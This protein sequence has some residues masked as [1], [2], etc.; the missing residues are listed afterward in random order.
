MLEPDAAKKWAKEQKEAQKVKAK[1]AK[2][3]AKQD[4]KKGAETSTAES[5]NIYVLDFDGDMKASA[6]ENFREEISTVLTMA[7]SSDEVVVR[8]ESPGGMVHSYGL[9]SSPSSRLFGT[10]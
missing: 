7:S 5:K 6:V 10:S 3:L 2:R 9:A 1:E 4:S 8:L